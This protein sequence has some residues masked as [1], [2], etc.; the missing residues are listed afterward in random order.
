M[1]ILFVAG[2][3]SKKKIQL[4]STVEY[5]F[6]HVDHRVSLDDEAFRDDDKILVVLFLMFEA[7]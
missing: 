4:K 6:Y 7:S 3:A 1:G 5:K 2:L